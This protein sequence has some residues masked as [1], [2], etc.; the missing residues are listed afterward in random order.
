MEYE[1]LREVFMNRLEKMIVVLCC[2]AFAF[3][4]SANICSRTRSVQDAIITDLRRQL[5]TGSSRTGPSPECSEIR[6]IIRQEKACENITAD[7]LKQVRRLTLE[8]LTRTGSWQRS[9]TPSEVSGMPNL[10]ELEVINTHFNDFPVEALVKESPNLEYVRLENNRFGLDLEPSSVNYGRKHDGMLSEAWGK[11]SELKEFRV[12]DNALKGPLPESLGN[13]PKLEKLWIHEPGM[14]GPIPESY[15]NL[16]NLNEVPRVARHDPLDFYAFLLEGDRQQECRLFDGSRETLKRAANALMDS[17][18]PHVSRLTSWPPPSMGSTEP[19][20]P[21]GPLRLDENFTHFSIHEDTYAS[22]ASRRNT[23]RNW[24]TGTLLIGSAFIPGLN[25][26][27]GIGAALGG[28]LLLGEGIKE[29]LDI[30]EHKIATASPPPFHLG[31]HPDILA[32]GSDAALTEFLPRFI[33]GDPSS[34]SA[35]LSVQDGPTTAKVHFRFRRKQKEDW[36]HVDCKVR[37][38][39]SDEPGQTRTAKQYRTRRG[40]MELVGCSAAK[41]KLDMTRGFYA[42]PFTDVVTLPKQNFRLSPPGLGE[43]SSDE[44]AVLRQAQA[45]V[46]VDD[47]GRSSRG[48]RRGTSGGDQSGGGSAVRGR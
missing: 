31:R 7:H 37:Y 36:V 8:N 23:L 3:P 25:V 40:E 45:R 19:H 42:T 18:E 44:C 1:E 43:E 11:F 16:T 30:E 17:T 4:V 10:R 15:R 35:N 29:K 24:G 6:G 14:R 2:G 34:S 9:L 38:R 27:V 46:D 48:R 22:D 47:S 5:C 33:Y 32:D 41:N 21:L 39:A 12:V 13:L 20:G 26:I 28:G